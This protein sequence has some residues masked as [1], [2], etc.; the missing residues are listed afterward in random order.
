MQ[1][2]WRSYISCNLTLAGRSIHRRKYHHMELEDGIKT[3]SKLEDD[4]G[5]S[6]LKIRN[7]R[8]H[9]PFER[10]SRYY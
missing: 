1:A 5:G 8:T 10:K 7:K 9:S 3:R 4:P 6:V 2:Q